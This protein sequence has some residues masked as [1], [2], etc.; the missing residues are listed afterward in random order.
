M[1][2]SAAND[3]TNGGTA[4]RHDSRQAK[5]IFGVDALFHNSETIQLL[6][7]YGQGTVVLHGGQ[8]LRCAMV[9]ENDMLGL[10]PTTKP[11]R[12]SAL[13]LYG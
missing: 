7:L 12:L 13:W 4:A 9:P 5:G 1:L 11:P 8:Q 3:T 2:I 10:V 6:H